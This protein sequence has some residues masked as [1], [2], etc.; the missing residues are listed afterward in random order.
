M[1]PDRSRK[2]FLIDEDSMQT[3]LRELLS[4]QLADSILRDLDRHRAI[5]QEGL[6]L[7]LGRFGFEEGQLKHNPFI[8]LLIKEFI[9]VISGKDFLERIKEDFERNSS[10]SM[11]GDSRLQSW[12]GIAASFKYFSLP[13]A[14]VGC[15]EA[16]CP[17]EGLR[18]DE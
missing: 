17:S 15:P 5:S 4:S 18:K 7:I 12:R 10:R 16:I 3:A 8:I 9:A 1:F 13:K 14:G 6:I 2:A 11:R